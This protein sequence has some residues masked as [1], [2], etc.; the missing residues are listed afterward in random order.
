[1]NFNRVKDLEET[2]RQKDEKE[3]AFDEELESKDHEIEVGK[4]YCDYRTGTGFVPDQKVFFRSRGGGGGGGSTVDFCFRCF[5]IAF[6]P[7]KGLCAAVGKTSET[8]AQDFG[9]PPI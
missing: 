9:I 4:L 2:L 6:G 5:A 7:I 3:E 1:M 8:I